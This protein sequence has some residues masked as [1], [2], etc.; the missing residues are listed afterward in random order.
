MGCGCVDAARVCCSMCEGR[1]ARDGMHGWRD[2]RGR[3]DVTGIG[4]RASC[5]E[6]ASCGCDGGRLVAVRMSSSDVGVCRWQGGWEV[7]CGC[8]GN[9]REDRGFLERRAGQTTR[10]PPRLFT[11]MTASSSSPRH[12]WL[13]KSMTS[14]ERRS[15]ER[16]DVCC[17]RGIY[18]PDLADSYRHRITQEGTEWVASSMHDFMIPATSAGTNSVCSV[19]HLRRSFGPASWESV[20]E[21]RDRPRCPWPTMP[22]DAWCARS[23]AGGERHEMKDI[24]E[25]KRE[26]LQGYV[27]SRKWRPH[28]IISQISMLIDF[29][30]SAGLCWL[31]SLSLYPF[32]EAEA[33]S[34][35]QCTLTWRQMLA[36]NEGRRSR[37]TYSVDEFL[38]DVFS[39]S[40]STSSDWTPSHF[41]SAS[42]FHVP[43]INTSGS[44]HI[45]IIVSAPSPAYT[46]WTK[47]NTA[48]YS[49]SVCAIQSKSGKKVS[50]IVDWDSGRG[51]D[52]EKRVGEGAA[53]GEPADDVVW[54]WSADGAGQGVGGVSTMD[55]SGAGCA[56][57]R[58][59]LGNIEDSAQSP[60]M[61]AFPTCSWTRCHGARKW[62]ARE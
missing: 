28:R 58:I 34:V 56:P 18:V 6:E 38:H 5:R 41:P 49:P 48:S 12:P 8:T 26:G 1:C 46:P 13:H 42:T 22:L 19:K 27:L 44:P 30:P 31:H 35:K 54:G 51:E 14:R 16:R 3:R 57:I 33:A 9:G 20:L 39:A 2:V 21:A 29:S 40:S 50:F 23:T 37:Q 52:G 43:R 61:A 7:V 10:W 11:E 32:D 53:N 36:W 25:M 62:S 15:C 60:S 17:D 47:P 4:G 24:D 45:L 59:D 55:M